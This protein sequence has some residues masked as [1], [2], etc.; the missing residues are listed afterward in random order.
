MFQQVAV[1]S[2]AFLLLQKFLWLIIHSAL[3]NKSKCF[4]EAWLLHLLSFVCFGVV[5][6]FLLPENF[7]VCQT[8]LPDGWS[9]WVN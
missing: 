3:K 2:S 7:Q 6:Y 5:F 4:W 8:R 1:N 9:A